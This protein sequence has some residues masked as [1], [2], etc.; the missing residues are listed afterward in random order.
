ME[1]AKIANLESHVDS[2]SKEKQRIQSLFESIQRRADDMERL[3]EAKTKEVESLEPKTVELDNAKS[4]IY[5]LQVKIGNIEK[6]N[7][8][9]SKEVNKLKESVEVNMSELIILRLYIIIITIRQNRFN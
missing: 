8:T 3:L 5:D 9:L 4:E 6:E 1:R 2:L 7:L